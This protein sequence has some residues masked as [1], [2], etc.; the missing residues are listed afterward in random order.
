M[1]DEIE[2]KKVESGKLANKEHVISPK[3]N[4]D[5]PTRDLVKTPQNMNTAS[6]ALPTPHQLGHV[7]SSVDFEIFIDRSV[8][9]RER[10]TSH[11]KY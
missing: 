5:I 9:D 4:V 7:S 6:P 2:F 1:H 8:I 11:L 10:S 3:V